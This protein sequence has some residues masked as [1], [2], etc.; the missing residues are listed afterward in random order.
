MTLKTPNGEPL[1]DEKGNV[2]TIG[3]KKDFGDSTTLAVHYDWTKMDNAVTKYSVWDEA[4]EKW[5]GKV[6]LMPKRIKS[7]SMLLWII[8]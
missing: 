1:K 3:V 7:P 2:Y 8:R 5:K 4:N 6:P